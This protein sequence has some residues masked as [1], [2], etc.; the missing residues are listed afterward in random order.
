MGLRIPYKGSKKVIIIP[1]SDANGYALLM[2]R[3]N[4]Q[5]IIRQYI[6]DVNCMMNAIGLMIFTGL[7]R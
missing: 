5:I 6:I 4:G 1:D 7:Y 3:E 2:L